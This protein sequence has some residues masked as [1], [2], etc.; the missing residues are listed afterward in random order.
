MN[1]KLRPLAVS[2]MAICL[3]NAC[4]DAEEPPGFDGPFTVISDGD[5][6]EAPPE[7]PEASSAS[8]GVAGD[9]RCEEL[10][11]ASCK[12]SCEEDPS[13]EAAKL[14]KEFARER[15]A[16]AL[17]DEQ[18]YPRCRPGTCVDLVARVCGALSAEGTHA[19]ADDPGCGAALQLLARAEAASAPPEEDEANLACLQAS[20]D[21]TLFHD[22]NGA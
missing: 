17:E 21:E 22:C 1:H 4:P 14:L 7:S 5:G 10:V 8:D 20:A 19:C 15:C 9:P 11:T 2:L 6:G 3:C 12:P 18:G 13:C 16:A